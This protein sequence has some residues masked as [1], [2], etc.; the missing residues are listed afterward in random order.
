[1]PLLFH[2]ICSAI[3]LLCVN[4]GR[5]RRSPGWNV[6]IGL[7]VAS[8][9]LFCA[10]SPILSTSF[11]LVGFTSC[12]FMN[13]RCRIIA[14]VI[15][16]SCPYIILINVVVMPEMMELRSYRNTYPIVSLADR[17]SYEA[18]RERKEKLTMHLS[19]LS[20]AR[21]RAIDQLDAI[22]RF[23]YSELRTKT[24]EHIHK[25]AVEQFISSPGF[26]VGRMW[27]DRVKYEDLEITD[28]RRIEFFR[29]FDGIRDLNNLDFSLPVDSSF[30]HLH[31]HNS[32][33]FASPLSFGFVKQRKQVAGFESHS[34]HKTVF[35]S[36]GLNNWKCA[37]VE[38][39]SLLKFDSPRVYVSDE[40]PAM[41][42]LKG[43]ATRTPDSFEE[44]S[45]ESLRRGNDLEVQKSDNAM[46]MVGSL[47]AASTCLKCHE[48][49]R[50]ELLGAFSYRF[51]PE[52]AK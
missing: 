42:K 9:C 44:E 2:L 15:A 17:L 7:L 14:T 38:L 10:P 19:G 29:T 45:L 22:R 32:I 31:D 8:A 18:S 30:Y 40:L 33:D 6:G 48:A 51:V 4:L 1:M 36:D 23:T 41:D 25:N 20:E 12:F 46:R 26:G 28:A 16:A 43:A 37:K 39:V 47:R 35:A 34:L 21:L 24:F 52:K 5:K 11:F 50:G 27:P 49:E 13:R 3:P